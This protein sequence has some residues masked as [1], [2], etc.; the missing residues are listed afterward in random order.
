MCSSIIALLPRGRRARGRFAGAH[1]AQSFSTL[2]RWLHS[3]A[4]KDAPLGVATIVLEGVPVNTRIGHVQF[5]AQGV[6]EQ[7]G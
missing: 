5:C 7:R 6:S 4:Y 2:R 1:A 3:Q